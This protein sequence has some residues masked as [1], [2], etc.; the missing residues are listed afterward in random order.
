MAT[1]TVLQDHYPTTYA[2]NWERL[3]QQEES[4]LRQYCGFDK[5]NGV[6]KQYNQIGKATARK[7]ESL[8]GETKPT[9]LSKEKRHVRLQGYDMVEWL[10]EFDDD[11]LGEITEPR[12]E[13][14][15]EHASGMGRK[16]DEVIIAAAEGTNYKGSTGTDAIALPAG[17]KI[18]NGGTDMTLAKLIA[19]RKIFDA[20]EAYDPRRGDEL[21][22][23]ITST[24]KASMLEDI[25]EISSGDYNHVKALVEGEVS[26]TFLGF[27]FIRTELLTKSGDIRQCLAWVKRAMMLTIQIEST[28]TIDRLPTRNNTVQIRTV[29]LLGATRRQEEGVV[30]IDC[31][32]TA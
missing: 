3:F 4:R 29:K 12:S 31:D 30:Q 19:A 5:I 22:M 7:I 32:E 27:K 2:R 16:C 18:V 15:V 14:V 23:A 1:P 25:N 20:N 24:Q 28:V 26:G 13:T 21:I 8:Y 9:N 11:L 10:D 6:T 17:Q